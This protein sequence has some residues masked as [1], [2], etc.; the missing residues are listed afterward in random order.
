MVYQRI[1]AASLVLLACACQP[2][3]LWGQ[4]G[5]TN[6]DCERDLDRA[7]QDYEIGALN[8]ISA[9]I[10][11]CLRDKNFSSKRLMMDGYRLLT[12]T[13]LFQNEITKATVSFENLLRYNPLFQV[14]STD[15]TASFDLIYLS[16][17]YQ[18]RPLVC[19]YGALGMNYMRNDILQ[20]YRLFNYEAGTPDQPAGFNNPRGFLTTNTYNN[21]FRLGFN[22]LLGVEV[23]LPY[24]LEVGMELGFSRRTYRYGAI[25][26]VSNNLFN[27]TRDGQSQIGAGQ[28]ILEYSRLIFREQQNWLDLPVFARYYYPY[29]EKILPYAYLGG[30]VHF[31]L[32]AQAADIRRVTFNEPLGGGGLSVGEDGKTV[33]L[34]RAETMSGE[35]LSLRNK[36]NWSGILGLGCKFR[37]QEHFIFVDLRYNRFFLNSVNRNNRYESP[38]LLYEYAYVDSDVRIDN[39]ML[40]VGFS[41]GFYRPRK[42]RRYDPIRIERD[43]NR[44]IRKERRALAKETNEDTRREMNNLLNEMQRD[45][46]LKVQSVQQ[47]RVD[48]DVYREAKEQIRDARGGN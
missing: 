4:S 12:E 31:L 40:S 45:F 24:N 2:L 16:K 18:H 37:W 22:T 34:T 29:K 42:K 32:G 33:S 36:T 3:V 6:A 48:S 11:G 27:P 38:V 14:D 28:D 8:R 20:D 30:A 15:K 26:S 25:Q 23:P 10:E 9:G 21:G 13:Y 46:P 35:T 7:K 1:F 5:K 41:Y 43:F 39:L 17:T 19:V 44:L 47:G